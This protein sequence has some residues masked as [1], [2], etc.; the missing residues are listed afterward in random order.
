METIITTLVHS[1][2]LKFYSSEAQAPM[3]T[4][5]TNLRCALM[6][7]QLFESKATD[8]SL[9]FS[10]QSLLLLQPDEEHALFFLRILIGR[11]WHGIRKDQQLLLVNLQDQLVKITI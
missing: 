9:P 1:V 8:F 6:T 2:R 11:E 3:R 4:R 7:N 5:V 10:P